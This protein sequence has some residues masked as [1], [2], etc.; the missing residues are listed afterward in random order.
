MQSVPSSFLDGNVMRDP[1][2]DAVVH[3]LSDHL[4]NTGRRF[5]P[6]SSGRPAVKKQCPAELHGWD[7]GGC[8]ARTHNPGKKT[9]MT[10]TRAA[11]NV[12]VDAGAL[13]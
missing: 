8:V 4:F 2:F 1:Q 13:H 5:I 7:E 12:L 9:G 11:E 6:W 3:G 10:N